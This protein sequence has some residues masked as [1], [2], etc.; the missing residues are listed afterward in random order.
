[1]KGVQ[2]GPAT[3]LKLVYPGCGRLIWQFVVTGG[4]KDQAKRELAFAE[5][6]LD[7]WGGPCC[8]VAM[9]HK[10]LLSCRRSVENQG[11]GSRG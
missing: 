7:G 6:G 9:D 5:V 11:S 3:G 2:F 1:M 4:V 8:Q 10:C